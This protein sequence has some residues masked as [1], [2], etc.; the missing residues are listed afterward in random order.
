MIYDGGY[1][2]NETFSACAFL[3]VVIAAA[4]GIE[5]ATTRPE[6]P[7]PIKHPNKRNA[8]LHD[9]TDVNKSRSD[10]MVARAPYR[11]AYL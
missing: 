1:Y 9:V 4:A 10:L 5:A 8:L 3:P 7:A 6:A 11:R 2:E